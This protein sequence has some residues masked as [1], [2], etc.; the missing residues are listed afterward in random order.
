MVFST[1]YPHQILVI[2]P[3]W[4]S[5]YPRSPFWLKRNSFFLQYCFAYFCFLKL[6][7]FYLPPVECWVDRLRIFLIIAMQNIGIFICPRRLSH[8]NWNV[9]IRITTFV[10]YF[11]YSFNNRALCFQSCFLSGPSLS[12]KLLCCVFQVFLSTDSFWW[13]APR[14]ARSNLKRPILVVIMCVVL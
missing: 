10:Q 9:L 11:L 4:I 12:S 3:L 1:C 6:S 13:N 7:D 2:I 5:V 14:V 8:L